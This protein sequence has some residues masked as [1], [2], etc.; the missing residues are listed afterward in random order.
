MVSTE[1]GERR[2]MTLPDGSV[3]EIN[4]GTRAQ[5]K[6]YAG[7]RDVEL[8]SGEINFTV[9]ADP[10]RPFI[11]DA[12]SGVVRV[13]GTVFDVRRDADQVAVLVESGTVQVSGGHWWNLGRAVLRAGHDG[14][15][16][17]R[18]AGGVQEHAPHRGGA[19]NEPLSGHAAALGG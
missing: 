15:S 12:G 17:A 18:W 7:R 2:Q 13:T 5:G 10:A 14:H 3:L 9:S 8:E 11:V 16:L 6:L 19:R 4:G 1:R